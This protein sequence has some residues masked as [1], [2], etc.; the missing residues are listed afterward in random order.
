MQLNASQPNQFVR[1]NTM[2]NSAQQQQVRMQHQQMVANL[3]QQQ[4]QL[5]HNMG[6]QQHN[7]HYHQPFNWEEA[8]VVRAGCLSILIAP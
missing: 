5:Q 3:Q 1:G 7:Q 4:Q 8:I 6:Q 2:P